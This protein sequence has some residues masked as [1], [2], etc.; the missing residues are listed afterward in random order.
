MQLVASV[1]IPLAVATEQVV[2]VQGGEVVA[3]ALSFVQVFVAI[4][5]DVVIVQLLVIQSGDDGPELEQL[6]T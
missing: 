5:A 2:S 1:G 4:G 6:D 3:L